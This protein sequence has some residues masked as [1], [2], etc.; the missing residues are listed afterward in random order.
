MKAARLA[1]TLMA[2]LLCLHVRAADVRVCPDSSVLHIPGSRAGIARFAAK[3]QACKN[4]PSGCVTIWHIGGS[5]VQ[6][7]WFSSR[8]RHNF[9]SLG[10]YPCGGRGFIFP[11]PLAHTNYDKSFTCSSTGEWTGSLSS[12]PNRKM[13]VSPAFGINGIAAYTADS[14]ASFGIR[15]P[16]LFSRIHI[17]GSASGPDV[18]PRISANGVSVACRPDSLFSG[19]VADLPFETD[20]VLIEPC[21]KEGQYFT[22]TGILPEETASGVRYVSTGVNGAR[23]NTW[24]TRCP[25]FEREAAVVHP[26]LAIL[27]LGINDS[28]CPPERFDPE[29]F[30]QNYRKLISVIHSVSPDCTLLFITNNDSWRWSRRHMVHNENGKAV[31][32]AMFELA[33]E[34]DAAVWDLFSLM[35]GNGSAQDWRDAGLMK[36][37]RL[38]FTREGYELLGDLLYTALMRE[39]E[40]R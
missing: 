38:H 27:A 12:N 14:T 16:G 6:A 33:E 7:G 30:K 19:F 40:T 1:L 24:T 28:A 17:T 10:H 5:H 21:L 4:S 22:V 31:R 29:R 9:D 2:A 37:D 35:G 11:Y 18:C 15:I 3:L 13:P 23:T 26:D 36:K 8:M 32:K 39:C 20:T 25:E 34:Y